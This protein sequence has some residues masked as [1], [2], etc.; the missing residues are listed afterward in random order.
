M[1]NV[2]AFKNGDKC[3]ALREMHC[4]KCTFFKTE[5]QFKRSR[6]ASRDRIEALPHKQSTHIL[7]KYYGRGLSYNKGRGIV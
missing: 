1:I 7:E 3:S 2:C 6:V 4:E 5:S